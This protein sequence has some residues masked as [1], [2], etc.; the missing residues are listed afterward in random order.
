MKTKIIATIGPSS[1]GKEVIKQ[2]IENGMSIIRIN[3]SYGNEDQYKTILKNLA[4][5]DPLSKVQK[6]LDIK[7]G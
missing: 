3:T 6:M 4:E 5:S 7:I 2:L 1:L